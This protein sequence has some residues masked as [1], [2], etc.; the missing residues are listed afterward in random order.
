MPIAG[1][2]DLI[3]TLREKEN[4][5]VKA[6]MLDIIGKRFESLVVGATSL[7]IRPKIR[8][9]FSITDLGIKRREELAKKTGRF[10]RLL[11]GREGGRHHE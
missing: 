5:R 3:A 8:H 4:D 10:S 6:G 9:T 1:R 2:S 11:V 7:L